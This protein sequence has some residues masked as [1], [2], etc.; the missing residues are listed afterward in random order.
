M[1]QKGGGRQHQIGQARGVGHELF[2]HA[3]K[4]VVTQQ[5]APH[6]Q[7]VR[8]HHCRIGVLY[9]QHA[10]RRAIAQVTPF[11][12]QHRAQPAHVQHAGVRGDGVQAVQCAGVQPVQAA[13][14]VQRAAAR[15]LP[16]AGN[17]RQTADRV[18]GRRTIAL[19]GKPITHTQKAAPRAAIQPGKLHN[20]LDR[21][22]GDLGR[23]GRRAAGQMGFHLGGEIGVFGQIIP[24]GQAFGQQHMHH[25]T[26]QRAIGAGA[27]SQVHI[28]FGGSGGAV[29]V[30]HHQRH[31]TPAPGLLQ[32]VHEIHLG[33][34]RVTA[35]DHNQLGL[36]HLTR[37]QPALGADASQPAGVGQ[38]H[39]EGF[40]LARPAGQVAQPADGGALHHAHRAG[41]VIGPDALRAVAGG[42]ADDALGQQIQRGAPADRGELAAALVAHPQQ[43]LG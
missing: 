42:G 17:R 36:H 39:A 32:P 6:R 27:Q 12:S 24:V 20:L 8:R 10:D 41:V 37:V 7:A 16:G 14:A 23:P 35:P 28:G 40:P 31:L 5:A 11:T 1:L 3:D 26:G 33:V 30:H 22:A 13:V 9:Q 21:Q 34:H 25:C 38:G 29:G 19:A 15:P 4:Q 18:H 2:V 43:R